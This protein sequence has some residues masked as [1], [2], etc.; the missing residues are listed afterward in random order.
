MGRENIEQFRLN[1]MELSKVG[2]LPEALDVEEMLVASASVCVAFDTKTGEQANGST[3][4]LAEVMC[5]T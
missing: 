5:A 2:V 3:M 4:L 1:Q